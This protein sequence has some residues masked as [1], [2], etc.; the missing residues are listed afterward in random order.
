MNSKTSFLSNVNNMNTTRRILVVVHMSQES[1]QSS[2]ETRCAI[3]EV[4]QRSVQSFWGNPLQGVHT[5]L[6]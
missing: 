3:C 2:G 5:V 6:I 1:F 4:E